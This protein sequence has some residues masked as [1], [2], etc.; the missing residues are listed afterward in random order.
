M[1]KTYTR[2]EHQPYC[3]VEVRFCSYKLECQSQHSWPDTGATGVTS[4][5][6]PERE[7]LILQPY[8]KSGYTA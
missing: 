7:K 2:S 5:P 1:L 4:H 6:L 3:A 8:Y